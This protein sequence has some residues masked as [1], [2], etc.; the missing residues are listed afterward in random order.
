MSEAGFLFLKAIF[1]SA[2]E[3]PLERQ[4]LFGLVAPL[5]PKYAYSQHSAVCASLLRFW[6]GC[7]FGPF[8]IQGNRLS[9]TV[10]LKNTQTWGRGVDRLS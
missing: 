3:A 8:S 4:K 10:L 5:L 6:F 7:N 9:A 2:W 1:G